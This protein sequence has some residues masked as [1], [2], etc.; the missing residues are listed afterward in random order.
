MFYFVFVKP[1]ELLL[2]DMHHIIQKHIIDIWN[3]WK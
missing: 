2:Y 1:S 3:I